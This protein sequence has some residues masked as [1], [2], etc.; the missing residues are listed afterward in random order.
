MTDEVTSNSLGNNHIQE[1]ENLSMSRI[2]PSR[3]GSISPNLQSEKPENNKN[4]TNDALT[5]H[6][7]YSELRR[8]LNLEQNSEILN[9]TQ[10][11]I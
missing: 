8:S 10:K 7:N 11:S 2:E 9:I 3:L 5:Q 1:N 6:E 4:L